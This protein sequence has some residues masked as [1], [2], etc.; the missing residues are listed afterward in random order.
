MFCRTLRAPSTRASSA[1]IRACWLAREDRYSEQRESL[2]REEKPLRKIEMNY[3]G[4]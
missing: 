1:A 3:I 2:R 4:G